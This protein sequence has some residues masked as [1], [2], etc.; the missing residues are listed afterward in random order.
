M[1]LRTRD[2]TKNFGGLKAVDRCSVEIAEGSITGLIGPNGAGKTTLFN[3]VTGFLLADEGEVQFQGEDVTGLPPHEIAKRGLVRT[4]QTAAGFMR[5]TVLENLMVAPQNQKGESIVGAIFKTKTEA[6]QQRYNK[7]KALEVLRKLGL[8]D[9]RDEWVE[10]LS[11]GETK[12]LEI[13]RQLMV[14]PKVL[15]LDEP[16]SGVNPGFQVRM[17]G[18][19]NGLREKGLTFF[20]IEHNLNFIM[21]ISDVLHVMQ[22]GQVIASGTPEEISKDHQVIAAYL[23]AEENELA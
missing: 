18:Y 5:M 11:C 3:V 22:S 12:L 15:L 1:M 21:S 20:I 8:C 9:K 23:G 4:F 16:M 7:E 13:G 19:L 6:I 17:V 14:N 10:N 2:V